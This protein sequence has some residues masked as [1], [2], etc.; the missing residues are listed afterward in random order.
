MKKSKLLNKFNIIFIFTIVTL[1]FYQSA[2]AKLNGIDLSIPATNTK[3]NTESSEYEFK[4]TYIGLQSKTIKSIGF[5]DLQTFNLSNFEAFKTPG[6]YYGNDEVALIT[7]KITAIEAS[8]VIDYTRPYMIRMNKPIISFM[9][10]NSTENI[11]TEAVLNETTATEFLNETANALDPSN[12]V[13]IT[14]I[15]EI[16]KIVN[17]DYDGDGILNKYDNCIEAYNPDQKDPNLDGYGLICDPD[18]NNNGNTTSNDYDICWNAL[19]S[20]PGQSNWNPDCD[21]NDNNEIDSSDIQFINN[22]IGMPPGPSYDSNLDSD[23]WIDER[24]NCWFVRNPDQNDTDGDCPPKKP[25]TTDP[26]CGDVCE[27]TT[28]PVITILY[29]WNRTFYKNSLDLNF[30]VNEPTSWIGYSLDNKPNV[31]ITGNTTLTGLSNSSHNVI[32]Y[33][34][35]LAGNTGSN[36]TYFTVTTIGDINGDCKVDVKDLVLVIKHFGSYPGSVKPWNPNADINFDN[37]VDVKDMVLV[38]KYFGTYCHSL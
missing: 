34:I 12:T 6:I 20:T 16:L 7:F 27:E 28:P 22:N 2:I 13:G 37:K 38:N 25:Y 30:T 24:D 5:S 15:N 10:W 29:P 1:V 14:L 36:A 3:I 31:T 19:G 21:F 26:R 11:T 9:V 33:A 35:D 23:G 8:R 18:V 32:V 4:I 17:P